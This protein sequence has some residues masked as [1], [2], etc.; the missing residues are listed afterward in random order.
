MLI[1]ENVLAKKIA[2]LLLSAKNYQLG[3]VSIF[4][5]LFSWYIKF[6]R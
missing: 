2:L 5:S 3:K 6:S 1:P 4:D